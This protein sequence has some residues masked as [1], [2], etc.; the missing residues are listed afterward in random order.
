MERKRCE[1]MK[2]PVSVIIPVFNREA[3]VERTLMSVLHQYYRPIE[4]V[5][6]DNGSTDGSLERCRRF[7]AEHEDKDFTVKVFT[8]EKRGAAAARNKGFL[9]AKGTYVTFFDSDDIMSPDFLS[10]MEEILERQPMADFV[11]ARTRMTRADGSSFVRTAWKDASPAQHILT[12]ML[13]TQ[14]WMARRT[15]F[16]LS[17]AWDEQLTTWDDY[18]LGLRLL[19]QA[20]RVEW[21]DKVFHQIM[22]HEESQTGPSFSATLDACLLAL[23][24]MNKV[25]EDISDDIQRQDCRNALYV[26]A[27][28][29]MGWLRHEKNDEGKEK[30]DEWAASLQPDKRTRRVA[31]FLEWYTAKGFRGAW[32][33]AK[34]LC[35]R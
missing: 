7:A 26:R 3:F 21:C 28:T 34:S 15:F 5:V 9:L 32:R 8:E 35:I 29:L 16:L 17:G 11:M 27:R 25:V 13:N 18:E 30:V 6:V 4:L 20:Q 1:D 14:S 33:F 10:S 22:L 31:A 2:P 12:G 23:K 19:L 24:K